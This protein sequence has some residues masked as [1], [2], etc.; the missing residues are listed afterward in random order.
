MRKPVLLLA[1]AI[2]A[3][4]CDRRS[5]A[6]GADQTRATSEPKIEVVRVISQKLSTTDRLPAELTPYYAVSIYPRVSGYVEEI[7]VDRGSIVHRGQL[8]ARLSA[9]ELIAQRAEVQAK[10][11]ADRATY[12]RLK[13]AANTPGAVAKNEIELAEDGLKADLERVRSSKT[14]EDYLTISAP[15]D[16]VITERDVH[17]GAL[18][19]PPSSSS[20][21]H[22]IVRIEEDDHLRLTVPVPEPDVEGISERARAEFTVSSWPGQQFAGTI[23]RISHSVDER[24]R[25]MPVELDVDNRDGKLSPGMFAEVQWP[26]HRDRTTLFVPALAV[27]ETMEAT[28]IEVV[29]DDRVR[30]VSVKRGRMQGELVETFGALNEGD[31]VVAQGSEELAEGTRISVRLRPAAKA[32]VAEIKPNAPG[33]QQQSR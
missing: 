5:G 33:S 4:A 31:L 10:M 30:R 14:L 6:T 7:P 18:V 32:S 24:T 27:V 1:L 26:V 23:A 9:P 25:A 21:A 11:S 8:L 12:Q 28:Y 22:Q 3:S 17:P 29:R 2:F 13:D 20:G 15:F 16:G 19:G